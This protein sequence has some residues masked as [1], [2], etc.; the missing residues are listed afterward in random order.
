MADA[1]AR[2][3]EKLAAHAAF[4]EFLL[5]SDTSDQGLARV[6]E[7]IDV[8]GSGAIDVKELGT[9]PRQTPAQKRQ[10]PAG[11]AMRLVGVKCTANSAKKVLKVIDTDGSGEIELDEFLTFFKKAPIYFLYLLHK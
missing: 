2:R 8:D 9:R 1:R 11:D 10:L 6:F 5:L 7:A 4:A 3:K